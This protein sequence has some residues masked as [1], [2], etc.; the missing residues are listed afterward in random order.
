M[1]S[2]GCTF[3]EL[4]SF[5]KPLELVFYRIEANSIIS[6]PFL[7]DKCQLSFRLTF[8]NFKLAF[9]VAVCSSSKV[10]RDNHEA[11]VTIL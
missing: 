10:H 1:V 9:L 4:V 5:V 6:N 7:V 11:A 8:V 2:L 3:S